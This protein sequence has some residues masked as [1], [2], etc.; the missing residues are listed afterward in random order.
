MGADSEELHEYSVSIFGGRLSL[1]VCI[2]PH[3]SHS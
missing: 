2:E 3:C 1:D